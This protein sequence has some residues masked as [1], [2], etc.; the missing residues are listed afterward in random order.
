MS[1]RIEDWTPEEWAELEAELRRHD[2]LTP[3]RT[4]NVRRAAWL[5]GLLVAAC[6]LVTL[7]PPA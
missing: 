3:D 6:I 5:W 2:K 4:S 7:V 1:R